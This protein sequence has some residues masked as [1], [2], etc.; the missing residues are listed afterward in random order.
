MDITLSGTLVNFHARHWNLNYTLFAT[1]FP[2]IC[3]E[4]IQR[5]ITLAPLKTQRYW[6]YCPNAASDSEINQ[7]WQ[8]FTNLP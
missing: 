1:K 4:S 2:K 7:L 3:Q 6:R 8:G 5:N